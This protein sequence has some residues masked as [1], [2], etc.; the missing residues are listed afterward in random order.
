M[1]EEYELVVMARM[2]ECDNKMN[3]CQMTKVLEGD[4]E[5]VPMAIMLECEKKV[6]QLISRMLKCDK[7]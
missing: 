2:L 7:Q 1:R 4:N 5:S 3:Q 6:N